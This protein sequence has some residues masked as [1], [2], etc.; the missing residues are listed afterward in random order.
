MLET[1]MGQGQALVG[2]GHPGRGKIESA[3]ARDGQSRRQ[4]WILEVPDT[5]PHGWFWAHVS[6]AGDSCSGSSAPRRALNLPT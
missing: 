1:H 5:E 2:T 6:L 4:G 3:A